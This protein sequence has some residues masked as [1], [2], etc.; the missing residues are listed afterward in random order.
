MKN[1]FEFADL[2]CHP[3]LKTYGHSF[4][5]C[6]N[7]EKCNVWYYQPPGFFSKLLST[8]AGV[9]RFSQADFTTL[10]KGGAKV[11]FA[12]LYPFEKGFFINAAG[13]GNLSAWLSDLVTGIGFKRV[14]NIQQHTNYFADLEK[15]YLF[16]KQ[17]QK[18]NI[19]NR[20]EYS[21]TLTRSWKEVEESLKTDNEIAVILTIEGTHVFNSGLK[22]FGKPV[23]EEEVLE[24]IRRIK[25]WE[26]PP[27]FMTFAHNF[28]NDFCGHASSLDP[29]SIF[30][31]QSEGLNAGFTILG[32]KVLQ[33]LLSTE[34]GRPIYIDIKHMS[35]AARKE[36]FEMLETDFPN[37]KYPTIV[38]HGA[39]NGLKWSN[40]DTHSSSVFHPA[41][42]NFYDE[43]I[44]HIAKNDGLFAIQFDARRIA[45]KELVKKKLSS[46][47]KKEDPSL[48]AQMIWYQIKHIAE[49]LDDAGY[50]GWGVA[51]IGSDYDGTIDPL[52]GV[53]TAEYF[54][55]ICEP[56]LQLAKDYLRNE[57]SLSLPE[58][59]KISAEDIVE[60]FFLKNST[61][62]LK[63]YF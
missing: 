53:W 31:D 60:N 19:I 10:H 61:R 42:I 18:S 39:V 15:E 9:T 37:K 22:E 55:F 30:V 48:A 25:Q 14:R 56:I 45:R 16:F 47:F 38:S 43:E 46:L 4:D 33:T 7:S 23:H 32:K 20:K 8:L 21:W 63:Q 17:S 52:P 51:C 57:N 24:N 28:N 34:N 36:Y 49:V 50:F 3:N 26:F 13:S 54:P 40:L 62:F 41:D 58:N 6:N 27:L 1:N 11:I 12:S 2:H 59:K 29:I 44:V 5:K 35:F